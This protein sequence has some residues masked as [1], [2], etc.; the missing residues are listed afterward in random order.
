[1]MMLHTYQ[2]NI[3]TLHSINMQ[4]YDLEYE[5]YSLPRQSRVA[6]SGGHWAG[7]I[8]GFRIPKEEWREKFDKRQFVAACHNATIEN[9]VKSLSILTHPQHWTFK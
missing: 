7:K 3:V 2:N 9:G 8:A 5:A 4:D 6:D 1:M